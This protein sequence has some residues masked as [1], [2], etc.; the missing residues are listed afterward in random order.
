MRLSD[1][2]SMPNFTSELKMFEDSLTDIIGED[3][4]AIPGFIQWEMFEAYA[5][6]DSKRMLKTLVEWLQ[7]CSHEKKAEQM[8]GQKG[9]YAKKQDNYGRR[10][11]KDSQTCSPSI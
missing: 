1:Y 5:E 8:F 6:Q 4:E 3:L 11:L 10:L 2:A 7:D 9:K